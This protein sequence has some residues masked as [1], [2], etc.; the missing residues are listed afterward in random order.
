M[1][2]FFGQHNYFDIGVEGFEEDGEEVEYGANI[3]TSEAAVA[4]RSE[5]G[6]E[7]VCEGLF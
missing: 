7:Y 3:D 5:V 4:N 2:S 6:S 1:Q